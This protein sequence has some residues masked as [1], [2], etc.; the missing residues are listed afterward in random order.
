M[1]K[2][3]SVEN[4]RK[5]DAATIKGGVP[6]IELMRRAGEGIL[7]VLLEEQIISEIRDGNS[8]TDRVAIL[9]GSGNNA[10]DGYVLALLLQQIRIPVTLFLCSDHFSEDGQYYHD[11]CVKAGIPE[12][13]FINVKP[14]TL[15][16]YTLIVDCLL[17]TGFRGSPKAPLNL[18]IQSVQKLYTLKTRPYIVSVDIN[19]GLNGDNGLA[20]LCIPS[21][22]TI[23]IGDPKPGLYLGMAKDVIGRI[24]NVPIG[25]KP[26]DSPYYL[27]EKK[28]VQVYF[29]PRKNH[30]NKGT[31]GYI[32]LIGGSF[33]YSGAI[34]L[35]SMASL[36]ASNASACMRSGAGVVMV[37]TPRSLCDAIRPHILE[38]TLYPLAE[39]AVPSNSGQ[40]RFVESEIEGLTSRAGVIALG[41]GI[42][43]SGEVEK[44]L[45]YLLSNYKGILVIDADALTV[46]AGMPIDSLQSAVCSDIVLTP[47]PGEFAR[48]SK[49]TIPEIQE[50]PIQLAMNY[51][52]SFSNVTLLLKGETT[53]I[54]DGCQVY[55][56]DRG[57]AG[58]ATAGSGDV[59]SGILSA[60][61]SANRAAIAQAP[62]Q[63]PEEPELLMPLSVLGA[64]AAAAYINGYA[65][66]LAQKRMGDVSMLASDT[67][68]SLPEAICSV[69]QRNA[70]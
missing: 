62:S 36:Q 12:R 61:L 11:K 64:T 58:M 40:F 26:I 50:S 4:M 13:F 48:L 65:G 68:A 70:D 2:L 20:D 45:D 49:K 7:R 54:T 51:A 25:I 29:A 6:G 52:A 55:L 34:S 17:G 37:A 63:Q 23:S 53:I 5:S 19:S 8:S 9:C 46:L 28:D 16:S 27:I 1:K 21:D 3:L 22:L 44:L 56:T 10:G 42:G 57:C 67:I 31:Y 14:S 30:S 15:S 18:V 35:A 69:S 33:N 66:E 59:L 43:I 32:A 60:V 39:C 38:S 47:H 41:M 24:I